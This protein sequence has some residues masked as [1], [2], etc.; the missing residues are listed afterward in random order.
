MENSFKY[1]IYIISGRQSISEFK[2]MEVIDWIIIA[3]LVLTSLSIE[4]ICNSCSRLQH[5]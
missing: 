5:N 3:V 1:L 2:L 4:Y